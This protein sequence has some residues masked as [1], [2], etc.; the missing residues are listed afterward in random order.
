MTSALIASHSVLDMSMH[1]TDTNYAG[2][3]DQPVSTNG[4]LYFPSCV[5]L[6]PQETVVSEPRDCCKLACRSSAFSVAVDFCVAEADDMQ[7]GAHLGT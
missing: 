3:A 7:N 6:H 4:C 2:L 5:H 1:D